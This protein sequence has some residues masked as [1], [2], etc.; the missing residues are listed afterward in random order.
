MLSLKIRHFVLIRETDKSR[1]WEAARLKI[2]VLSQA[3]I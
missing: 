1:V 2:T 3:T